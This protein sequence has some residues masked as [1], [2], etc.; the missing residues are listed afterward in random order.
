METLAAPDFVVGHERLTE[1][2]DIVNRLFIDE[3]GYTGE[4]LFNKDQPVF[5]LASL[6]LSEARCAELKRQYFSKVQAK[7][8]K[9]SRLS[10]YP[11]QQRMV[12]D[13]LRD[14]SKESS[15]VKFAIAHKR[16]IL[17]TK[18][19]DLLIEPMAY[20]DGLDFYEKGLNI[21]FSNM[22][23]LQ[24]QRLAGNAFF[25][26][27]LFN[28]QRMMR[29]RTY[30]AYES[31]FK[32]FFDTNFSE[33]LEECFVLLKA[34]HLRYG[35]RIL[36]TIP[37]NSLEFAFAHAF[38]LVARWSKCI[39]GNFVI[40]H[41][42]SSNMARN[43]KAWDK[44]VHPDVP[45]KVVGYDRRKMYF[46]IRAAETNFA[47]SENFAGLQLADI[48]AGAM[49][50]CLKWNVEDEKSRDDYAEELSTFLPESFSGHRIWPSLD[51]TPEELGTVGPNAEDAIEHFINL[52]RDIK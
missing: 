37:E 38:T 48:M 3:C 51:V 25:E 17:I 19:V 24:T 50:R 21:A 8:L 5:V 29:E 39:S 52:T 11:A 20:E 14:M 7:E 35:S 26:S 27:M 12:I 9:H 45:P 15:S 33:E 23:F 43:K 47:R 36:E 46:P 6:Y 4:D 49:A 34:H 32:P 18:I 10:K 28:F 42:E 22:L 13:F 44:V 1:K 31:F 41:D 40:T 30:E 2:V 16:F